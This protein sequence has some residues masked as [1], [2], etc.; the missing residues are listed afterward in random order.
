[1]N[2]Y[3]IFFRDACAGCLIV[4]SLSTEVFVFFT[5]KNARPLMDKSLVTAKSERKNPLFE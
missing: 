2:L 1:M 4:F 5:D 3:D